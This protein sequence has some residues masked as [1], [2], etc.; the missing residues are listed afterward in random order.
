[1]KT[2]EL[3]FLTQDNKTV[4]VAVDEPAEPIDTVKVKN[5]MAQ[6]LGSG[7]LVSSSGMALSS[8]KGARL[9]EQNITEYTLA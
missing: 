6:M 4:R 1:M 2:L 9:I 7:V 3:Q 8:V 5:A